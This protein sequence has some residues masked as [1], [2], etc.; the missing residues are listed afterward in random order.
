MNRIL[1]FLIIFCLTCGGLYSQTENLTRGN[2]RRILLDMVKRFEVKPMA[3]EPAWS[4]Q[5]GPVLATVAWLTDMHI[6]SAT[7]AEKT[8]R[9]ALK[10]LNELKPDL[11]LITGDNNAIPVNNKIPVA[12]ARQRWFKQFLDKELRCPYTVIPGDNW[13]WDFEK[14]FGSPVRSFDL[15]GVH[16][17]LAGTDSRADSNDACAVFLPDTRQWLAN[18]L[19]RHHD[20]PCLF[21]LHET[22][23]PPLFLDA[24]W[25]DSLLKARPQV[26]AALSGH[27]HLDLEFRCSG[28]TQFVCPA[29]GPVQKPAFKVM[30]IT[31]D[32]LILRTWEWTGKRFEPAP[33][34]QRIVIPQT[35]RSPS[36]ADGHMVTDLKSM[37]ARPKVH[38]NSLAARAKEVDNAILKAASQYSIMNLFRK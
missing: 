36:A 25:T 22:V 34:W 18:D 8:A 37:P 29:L 23:F 9:T 19:D 17:V 13:P 31:A 14:V 33:K 20:R 38:D 28:Y 7:D 35:L 11:V 1:P 26:L 3:A 4:V 16:F 6:G 5:R 32:Q 27:V 2:N 30:S 12:E 21:V 10:Q 24:P 15:A